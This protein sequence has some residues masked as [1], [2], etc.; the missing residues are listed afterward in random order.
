MFGVFKKMFI[1]LLAGL[2]NEYNH[3]NCV[4]LNNQKCMTQ[5]TLINLHPIMNAVKNFATIHLQLN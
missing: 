1:G 2:V 3:G 5:P 4:S